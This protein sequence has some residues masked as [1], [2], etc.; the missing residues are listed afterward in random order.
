MSNWEL[1]GSGVPQGSVL[2]PL[3]FI[4]YIND[5]DEQTKELT[6]LNKFAD[7][8]KGT[9]K[10]DKDE[11]VTDLQ[12]CIN[13]LTDWATKW[14]MKFN[15]S[16]CKIMH[17]G[18]DNQQHTYTML[19][20]SLSTTTKER[21]VGVMVDNTLKP[22]EQ[23]KIAASRAQTVLTQISK[24]FHYRDRK[25]FLN[26][27]KQYVRPH[28]EF[29]VSAWS[30]WMTKDKDMLEKVQKRAVAM[31]SGLQGRTYNEKLKELEI[32]SLEERRNMIDMINT[33]KIVKGIDNVDSRKWFKLV[34]ENP[35]RQTRLTSCQYNI[36]KSTNKMNDVRRHFFSNRVVDRWNDLPTALKQLD[37]LN[38]FKY[39]LK[40]MMRNGEA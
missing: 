4:I 1:V 12:N 3:A 27:Y 10:I 8:T 31:I 20:E 30:P 5:I 6:A 17:L 32:L 15:V 22:A 33:F 13:K 35:A 24:T 26:L 18:K 29:A 36:V 11:D 40:K 16:K 2:G 9:N 19:G 21:D 7:D 25:I 38:N 37:N 34:G 23:C 28:L 39:Q 14:G